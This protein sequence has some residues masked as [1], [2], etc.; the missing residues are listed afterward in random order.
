[1]H[2]VSQAP[3]YF[4][5]SVLDVPA[6]VD[7]LA[8]HAGVPSEPGGASNTLEDLQPLDL[9]NK[10]RVRAF[11]FIIQFTKV[12]SN[13]KPIRVIMFIRCVGSL[14]VIASL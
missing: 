14:Q 10:K 5:T 13:Y 4:S 6:C 1:M 3:N 2:C 7:N 11:F 9:S 8:V 12:S